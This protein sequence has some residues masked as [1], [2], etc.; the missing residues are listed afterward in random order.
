MSLSTARRVASA[1][2][3]STARRALLALLVLVTCAC[4]PAQALADGDPGSDVLL[5]QNLFA[6]SDANLSAAQQLQ[7]GEL[8]NATTAVG[9]PIRVAIIAHSD[10]LGAVPGLWNK[11]E[12]YAPYLGIELSNTYSGRL[13]VVMP[14][15]FGVAW[16]GKKPGA[17]AMSDALGSLSVT[18]DSASAL[19][20]ATKAAVYRIEG[21]AGVSAGELAH[22]LSA[23]AP[24]PA[25]SGAPVATT[26]AA[27]TRAA[28][29]GNGT[30]H[31]RPDVLVIIF[32]ALFLVF[33]VA[34]RRGWRPKWRLR[35]PSSGSGSK[36]LSGSN[37]SSGS[38][39]LRIKSVALLP[40]GLLLIVV[41][42]LAVNHSSGGP[43]VTDG[44]LDTNAHLDQGT[45]LHSASGGLAQA[46]GFTLVDETGQQISLKQYRGKVVILGFIDAECQT[47]CPLTTQAMLNAK[48]SLGAAGK[49][50]QL[51]GIDANYKSTQIEDVANYTSLHGLTG[52]WHF[53]T[54]TSLPQLERVWSAYGV[55]EKALMDEGSNAIDHVAAVYIIDPQG[56][57][58]VTFVTQSS[59]SSIPQFGQ[60]L[61]QDASK[62]LRSHPKVSSHYSYA[63]ISGI[64]PT[65]T[66]ALP[67]VGGG[68]VTLGP[69]K[70]HLY[71]FFATWDSQTTSIGHELTELNAYQRYAKAHSLP[72]L[73]AVDEGSVEPSPQAL[74]DFLKTLP[75]PLDYPVA[76]DNSGKVADGYEVEGA[77]WLVLTSASGALA[78][79]Q[80]VYTDGW[81]TLTGLEQEVRG[82]LSRQPPAPTN[83]RAVRRDLADSPPALAALHAQS[84]QLLSGG[85]DS[86]ALYE[87]IAKLRGYPIVLNIWASTCAACQA[88]FGLFASASARY[89]KRVAFLGADNVDLAGL[90]K[91]FLHSHPVSYPSYETS[92][93][94][95]DPLLVGG[96]EGTPTTL[97]ISPRGHVIYVHTGQYGTGGALDL[98]IQDY[99]LSGAN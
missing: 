94:G 18:G 43:S 48:R 10:D 1:R 50:V 67:R 97:Y 19:V 22:H 65:Q 90:A 70:P 54:S 59:Y 68:T 35:R 37:G 44:T 32:G 79:Y 28:G 93:A 30:K 82:A 86:D 56:R 2:R 46:P 7:L 96:L 73:T 51:L 61:A 71:L 34:F 26:P 60:L 20:A 25:N 75:R 98:D 45:L 31:A 63:Q 49:D 16:D 21:A 13:L 5:L 58:R 14:S 27:G 72:T 80:E 74:P 88:E 76:I 17:T 95:I 6:A 91:A 64:S 29:A 12:V 24:A 15:G 39:R 84:G 77:P 3:V 42:A 11:P 41:V 81:P 23:A 92:T 4:V 53:L 66:Y 87:R 62:L 78:S 8:L 99:A 40:S 89:G 69:G 83:E 55:N 36:G 33:Y 47:I 57:L 9:Q 85:T 38:K 52:Q